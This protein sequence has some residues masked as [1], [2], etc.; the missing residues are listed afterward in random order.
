MRCYRQH[1]F[2]G[3]AINESVTIDATQKLP[4]KVNVFV[5]LGEFLGFRFILL[6]PFEVVP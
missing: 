4:L 2:A 5:L 6:S 3:S 1:R